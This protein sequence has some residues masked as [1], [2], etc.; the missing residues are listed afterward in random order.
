[1]YIHS[2]PTHI[3]QLARVNDWRRPWC[4]YC[5]Y[6]EWPSRTYI[7]SPPM[8]VPRPMRMVRIG[9]DVGFHF[10]HLTLT[11]HSHIQ[12]MGNPPAAKV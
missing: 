5:I 4:T 12:P 6:N 10:L 9:R 11:Q 8:G 2:Q 1:M 7:F 3:E